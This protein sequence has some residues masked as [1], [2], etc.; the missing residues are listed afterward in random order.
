VDD[1]DDQGDILG[2]LIPAR[3]QVILNERHLERL[4][5]KGGRLRRFTVG[6]EIGHWILHSEGQGLGTSP[7]FADGRVMCRDCSREPI[8]VQAEMFAA[9]LLMPQQVLDA[10]LPGTP[11]RGWPPV[12]RLAE[13]F[14]VNVTPMKIRLEGRGW[15][16][17][18]ETEVPVAGP[19]PL[20][21]HTTLF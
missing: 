9:A 3:R 10:A 20:P 15:M 14:A 1:Q 7:L 19:A 5:A 6:H 18:D 13:T 16:H 11:W 2:Q 4:E 8:E 17:L 12:Y 21:G